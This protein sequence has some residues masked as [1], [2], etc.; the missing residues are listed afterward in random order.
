[1][2]ASYMVRTLCIITSKMTTA[3]AYSFMAMDK[4]QRNDE[5]SRRS[6]NNSE[7]YLNPGYDNTSESGMSRSVKRRPRKRS[8]SSSRSKKDNR[9]SQHNLYTVNQ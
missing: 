2:R 6:S 1:M 7:K 4:R 8:S 3:I 5:V 9:V